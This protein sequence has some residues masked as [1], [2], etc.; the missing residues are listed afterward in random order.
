MKLENCQLNPVAISM[1]P[2]VRSDPEEDWL[3][4]RD[5]NEI[6][7]S[8][9]D[10]YR[11]S[12][13]LSYGS[14][15]SYLADSENLLFS[16]YCLTL[17]SLLLSLVDA[18]LYRREVFLADKERYYPHKH[19]D[20]PSWTREKT[21]MSAKRSNDAFRNLLL[22]LHAGL[23]TLSEIIAI[24]A[25]GK[26]RGLE[27]GYGQ[28]SK[29]EPWLMADFTITELIASPQTICLSKLHTEL[30]LLVHS[31]PPETDWLPYLRL[32]RNKATHLGHGFFRTAALPDSSGQYFTFVPREW[33]YIWEKYFNRN[34]NQT[35]PMTDLLL[36]TFSHQDMTEYSAGAL[37]KVVAVIDA[38]VRV[39]GEAYTLCKDFNLNETALAQ[40]Q[41]NSK[42]F[43][44]QSFV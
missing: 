25:E 2:F 35:T 18:H 41:S 37:R 20:D 17:R 33:P 27:V 32:L 1:A 9:F 15:P 40:L 38:G 14:A 13:Y 39:I 42:L 26:I 29:L 8:L 12:N 11:K 31:A 36:N 43:E 21:E 6:P 24:F 10:L 7:A 44:F 19:L 34:P 22:S 3:R 23:D 30:R 16:Y 28:F 4:A 5:D